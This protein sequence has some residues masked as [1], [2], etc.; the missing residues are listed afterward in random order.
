MTTHVLMGRHTTAP[1]RQHIDAPS[2]DTSTEALLWHE[3][4]RGGTSVAIAKA[5]ARILIGH[6]PKIFTSLKKCSWIFRKFTSLKKVIEFE[7]NS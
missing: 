7:K 3:I 5:A 1:C 2:R 6:G 4:T